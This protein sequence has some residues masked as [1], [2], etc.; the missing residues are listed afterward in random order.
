MPFGATPLDATTPAFG[1]VYA[2]YTLLLGLA[3]MQVGLDTA[4][5]PAR[6]TRSGGRSPEEGPRTLKSPRRTASQSKR[7]VPRIGLR[8]SRRTWSGAVT[9]FED[10]VAYSVELVRCVVPLRLTADPLQRDRRQG[11]STR[12]V[13]TQ[14]V[15]AR[16]GIGPPAV[17]VNGSASGK[18]GS[19]EVI[20]RRLRMLARPSVASRMAKWSPM[21]E[22]APAPNGRNCQR[23]RPRERSAVN[24]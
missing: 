21:H 5:Q 14:R 10:D 9:S 16:A 18:A 2:G 1:M 4:R 19:R 7:R 6:R 20:R 8:S 15:P 11:P 23:S 13:G 22:R 24:R 12:L 17:M 3:L